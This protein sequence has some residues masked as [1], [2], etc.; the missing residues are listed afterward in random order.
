MRDLETKPL[1]P[2]ELTWLRQRGGRGLFDVMVDDGGLF[3][4]MGSGNIPTKGAVKKV[5]LGIK[6]KK[7]EDN[8]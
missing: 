2:Q 1:T 5:Y 3:V 6:P 7:T 8:L 4:L